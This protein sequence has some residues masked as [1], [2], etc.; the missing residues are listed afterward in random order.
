MLIYALLYLTGYARPTIDDIKNFRQLGSPCAGH[1]E[2]FELPGS[3]SRP[4][5]SARASRWR[6]GWRSPS[7]I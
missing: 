2:N 5:R 4:A 7:G 6:S 3:R 1:P